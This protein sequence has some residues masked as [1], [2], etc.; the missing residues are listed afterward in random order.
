M[1]LPRSLLE[2]E[3][4]FTSLEESMSKLKKEDALYI[5]QTESNLVK[6]CFIGVPP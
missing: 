1:N 4:F 6:N 2:S 3:V 5:D